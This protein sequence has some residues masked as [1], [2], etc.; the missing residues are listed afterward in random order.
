MELLAKDGLKSIPTICFVS[1]ELPKEKF[2][3]ND[4]YFN[5]VPKLRD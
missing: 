4:L 2:Q 1:L 3:R 5:N